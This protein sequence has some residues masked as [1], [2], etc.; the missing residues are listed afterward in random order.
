[1]TQQPNDRSRCS[2]CLKK[3]LSEQ[4]VNVQEDID[5]AMSNL[6]PKFKKMMRELLL[7][8]PDKG[9]SEGMEK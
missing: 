9:K 7:H 8:V 2:Y 5:T 1:M 4:R 6:S 3:A